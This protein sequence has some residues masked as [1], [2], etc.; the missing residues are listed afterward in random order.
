VLAVKSPTYGPKAVEKLAAPVDPQNAD[1]VRDQVHFWQKTAIQVIGEVKFGPAARSLVTTLLTPAKSDLRGT[2]VAALL[3]I[4]KEGQQQLLLALTG[5]DAEYNKLGEAFGPEKTHIAVLGDTIAYISRPEGR[6]AVLRVL[7]ETPSDTNRVILAQAL[8]RFPGDGQVVKAFLDAYAKT[9]ANFQSPLFGGVY[10]RTALVQASSHFYD[11]SL[12]DWL[13]KEVAGATGDSTEEL[14][15]EGLKAAMKLMTTAKAKAVAD[16]TNRYGS[17]LDKQVLP[18]AQAPLDKCKQDLACY[19]AQLEEIVPSAPRGA[20]MKHI[21]AAY[22]LGMMGNAGTAKQLVEKL[23][24]VKDPGA[25]LAV[26]EAVDHLLPKGDNALADAIDKVVEGD[27]PSG[28]KALLAANDALVK[29][30]LAM[31]ARA[32]P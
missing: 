3:R 17:A 27:K 22:M 15:S 24:R 26:I 4:P 11:A 29:V 13:L 30:S 14:H 31:R 6:D 25:R 5:K 19:L 12:V 23:D 9:P 21:K 1:S 28:N 8:Y 32:M 2:A 7:G 20:N 16:A 10:G 18:L